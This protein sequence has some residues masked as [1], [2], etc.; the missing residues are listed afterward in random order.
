MPNIPALRESKER[1]KSVLH[2]IKS[3][4]A[5]QHRATA[6]EDPNIEPRSGRLNRDG[7][8]DNGQFADSL[9]RLMHRRGQLLD[10][11][12][13]ES[14]DA[15]MLEASLI[16][17]LIEQERMLEEEQGWGQNHEL[18]KRHKRE[19]N[20]LPGGEPIAV[21]AYRLVRRLVRKSDC[22]PK[23]KDT[24]DRHRHDS[25][26]SQSVRLIDERATLF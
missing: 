3:W 8:V 2:R 19:L 22:C 17:R 23:P 9:L 7:D 16:L 5:F 4:P 24:N 14:V 13:E 12:A 6:G 18:S 11:F 15:A 25:Y 20:L 10:P 1:C 26:F 21:A